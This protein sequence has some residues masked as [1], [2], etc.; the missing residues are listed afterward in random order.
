MTE[1]DTIDRARFALVSENALLRQKLQKVEKWLRR[2]QAQSERQADE[3]VGRFDS[4]ADANRADAS[5]FK[6]IADDILTVLK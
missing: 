5:N 3:M 2:L 4:L 6:A 1:Q